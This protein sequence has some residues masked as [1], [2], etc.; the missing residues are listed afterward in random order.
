MGYSIDCFKSFKINENE[1]YGDY[2]FEQLEYEN[3]DYIYPSVLSKIHE[4]FSSHGIEVDLVP[5]F[6][7]GYFFDYLTKEQTEFIVSQLKKPNE[8]LRI[9][10]DH[11]LLQLVEKEL[12]ECLFSFEHLIKRWE[13]GFYV[14]KVF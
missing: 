7:D 9:V 3:G 6:G 14:I 12:P 1:V 13:T 8:C 2:I 10:E 11:N 4:L 5:F